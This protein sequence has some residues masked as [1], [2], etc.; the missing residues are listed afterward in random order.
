MNGRIE[1]QLSHAQIIRSRTLEQLYSIREEFYTQATSGMVNGVAE[2]DYA[3]R[4]I[5]NKSSLSY[6]AAMRILRH[7]T[8]PGFKHRVV[9]SKCMLGNLRRA[10]S[11]VLQ[12][13]AEVSVDHAVVKIS[14]LRVHIQLEP[15]IRLEW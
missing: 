7:W 4:H 13:S 8:S 9:V 1:A 15:Q 10:R 11:A 6:C 5:R 3:S 12:A 2:L 14:A